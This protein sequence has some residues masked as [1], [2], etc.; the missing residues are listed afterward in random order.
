MKKNLTVVCFMAL[1]LLMGCGKANLES[2]LPTKGK[3]TAIECIKQIDPENTVEEINNIIGVEGKLVDEKY[4]KYY[5][6]LSDDSGV[7]V[8]YY[9]SKKGTIEI[10]IE[11]NSIANKKV[12]FSKYDDIKKLLNDGTSLTYDEFASKVGNV[13]G[14]L[15]ENDGYNKTYMWVN[16]KGGYLKATFSNRSGKCTFVVGRY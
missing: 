2:N 1:I 15:I 3:C 4:N 11:R 5:W 6:E 10:N 8:K 13:E 9:D 7:Y 16:D 14:T 12:D